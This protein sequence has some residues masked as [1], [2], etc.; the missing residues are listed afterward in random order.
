MLRCAP[1]LD[2]SFFPEFNNS[3]RGCALWGCAAVFGVW[4]WVTVGWEL[5]WDGLGG[6]EE[7][8]L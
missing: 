5:Y 3:R 4:V 6:R 2:G 8:G 1:S 7:R